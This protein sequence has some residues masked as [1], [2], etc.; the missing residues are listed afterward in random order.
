M[1]RRYWIAATVLILAF[2]LF[3]VR[4]FTSPSRGGY[5]ST[6]IVL[7]KTATGSGVLVNLHLPAGLI[8]RQVSLTP[9][10]ALLGPTASK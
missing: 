1:V 3:S 9:T 7:P 8:L 10:S 2:G 4:F 6:L 5:L